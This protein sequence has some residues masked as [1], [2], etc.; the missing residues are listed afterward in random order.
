MHA[1]GLESV[2]KARGPLVLTSDFARNVFFN[3]VPVM[4][5]KALDTRQPL[6][7]GEPEW[8]AAILAHCT[9]PMTQAVMSTGTLPAVLNKV[10]LLR[11]Q[12]GRAS[13]QCIEHLVDD[14]LDIKTKLEARMD[15]A[16]GTYRCVIRRECFSRLRPI[17]TSLASRLPFCATLCVL[18]SNGCVRAPMVLERSGGIRAGDG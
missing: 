16:L 17:L 3:F 11:S 1:K 15:M 14:I 13:V 2:F 5:I 6:F 7:M 10:D 8:Q 4:L 9:A 18:Q 12:S